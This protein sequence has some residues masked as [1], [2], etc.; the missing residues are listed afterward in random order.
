M[1]KLISLC[2]SDVDDDYLSKRLGEIFLEGVVGA[3]AI[4][5]DDVSVVFDD[6]EMSLAVEKVEYEDEISILDEEISTGV[7]R[8]GETLTAGEIALKEDA[9]DAQQ[10]KLDEVDKVIVKLSAHKDELISVDCRNALV[11]IY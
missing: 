3:E 9:R 5:Y 2:G 4:S 8:D 6:L 11:G 7:D 10:E 1:K